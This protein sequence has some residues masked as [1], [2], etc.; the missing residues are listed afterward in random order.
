MNPQN[1]KELAPH[2]TLEVHELLRTEITGYKKLQAIIPMVQDEELK[3][4]MKDTLTTKQSNIEQIHQ[5]ITA[6]GLMN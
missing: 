2:E 5:F 3:Q 4:F 6:Q 1:E